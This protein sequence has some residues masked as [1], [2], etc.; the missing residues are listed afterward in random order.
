MPD[1]KQPKSIVYHP[2]DFIQYVQQTLGVI[3]FQKDFDHFFLNA[4]LFMS[5][6]NQTNEALRMGIIKRNDGK[7]TLH[8]EVT[9]RLNQV[10]YGHIYIWQ[11]RDSAYNIISWKMRYPKG[12]SG[13]KEPE[14]PNEELI[15]CP[16][17]ENMNPV[18][19]ISDKGLHIKIR[20]FVP[21]KWAWWGHDYASLVTSGKMHWN[22]QEGQKPYFESDEDIIYSESLTDDVSREYFHTMIN[23]LTR[24]FEK[25]QT[26]I[27][28]ELHKII[29][30][31]RAMLGGNN[32][33]GEE[34]FDTLIGTTD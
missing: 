1:V 11:K 22:F 5:L 10:W 31:N 2:S 19:Q 6:M 25:Y 8:I 3:N 15:K 26:Y 16:A 24:E 17:L 29:E 12:V 20:E 21:I 13:I 14:D 28:M 23:I 30:D 33:T 27:F 9:R 34:D 32:Q 7:K 4:R 18:N